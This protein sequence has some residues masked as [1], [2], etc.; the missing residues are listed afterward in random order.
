MLIFPRLDAVE[1]LM[2]HETFESDFV[3]LV[4][5]MPDLERIVSRVHAGTCKIKDFLKILDVSGAILYA[6]CFWISDSFQSFKKLSRGLSEL[7]EKASFFETTSVAGLLRS[8]EDLKPYLQ[9]I[10]SMFEPP[11]EDASE[12][13]PQQ[14]KDEEYDEISGEINQ[15]E[16]ELESKLKKFEQKL[17]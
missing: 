9:N 5:G 4:K 1:D 7:A 16:R 3:G 17:G 2:R 10:R 15:I 6:N 13:V 12:L 14:G 11:S 8:V